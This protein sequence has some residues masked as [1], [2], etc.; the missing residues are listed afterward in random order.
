MDGGLAK[1]MFQ[2]SVEILGAT[3]TTCNGGT[4][5]QYEPFNIL[6]KSSGLFGYKGR[7]GIPVRHMF[8]YSVEIFWF[9]CLFGFFKCY[10]PL[11]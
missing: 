4:T 1:R 2:Y 10:P 11:L 5:K 3:C 7:Y 9:V 8:Q 6:L